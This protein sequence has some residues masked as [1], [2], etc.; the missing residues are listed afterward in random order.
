MRPPKITV[1]GAAS[2]FFGRP[3]IHKMATS[4]VFAGGTLALVD[5]NE[6]VLRTMMRLARRAFSQAHCGVRLIGSTDRRQVMKDS[7]FV[8]LTFSERNAHYRGLDTEIAAR[9]GIRMCSSD[10]IGPGGVFRALREAPR[11]VAMAKDAARLAPNAWVINFVNPTTVLGMA[12]RRYVPEVRSFALCDGHH[13]PYNTLNWCKRLGILPENAASVPPEVYQKLDLAIG[14]VN[15]CTWLVRC[16]YDGKDLMPKFRRWLAGQVQAE[17]KTTPAQG[18][19]KGSYNHAYALQLLDLYGAYPTAVGHTKEYVP[20]FQGYGAKPNRPEPIRLFD[21]VERAEQMAERW[22]ETQRYAS[23]KLSAKQFL[24]AQ[25]NDHATDIIESMWGGLGKQFY[26]N[27]PNRGA[28]TNLPDDAFLELRCDVDMHGPRPQPFGAFE[29][30]LLALQHQVLDTHE[31]TAEAA[32]TGDRTL[33][34]RAMLTDPIC[35]NIADADACI[36][37]LLEAERDILPS[38]WY[39]RRRR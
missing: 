23:G 9:H 24:K 25:A 27:G 4:N 37:D 39:K 3:V 19:S 35:N 38:Y 7:D 13:E 14:G 17:K 15:H 18:A 21:A 29:R 12:L 31:L 11:A 30:G 22:T 36:K 16:R 1:I 2:Y 28:V 10:T 26:I 8:V 5:T 6:N 20:F 33:L 32:M 34:R